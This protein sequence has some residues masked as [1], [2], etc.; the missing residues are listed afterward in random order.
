MS[1]VQ[2]TSASALHAVSEYYTRDI[3]AF[4]LMRTP[5]L[6]ASQ[7]ALFLFMRPS[8]CLTRLTGMVK[9]P[10]LP[11]FHTNHGANRVT[12]GNERALHFQSGCFCFPRVILS[13]LKKLVRQLRACVSAALALSNCRFGPYNRLD[14]LLVTVSRMRTQMLPLLVGS[15]TQ[16]KRAFDPA[17]ARLNKT[18]LVRNAFLKAG[19]GVSESSELHR[20]RH[21]VP[22]AV[23]V[24]PPKPSDVAF[25]Q[26]FE[27]GPPAKAE[28]AGA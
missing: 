8:D 23:L 7:L 3:P 26:R 27:W 2:G 13:R 18:S 25:R 28:I 5:A 12:R 9:P 17:A 21:A 1:A 22:G 15:V 4:L 19:R 20:P 16:R 24:R 6:A 10:P 14:E 11:S